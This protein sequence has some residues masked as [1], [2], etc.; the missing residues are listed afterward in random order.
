[1]I[2]VLMVMMLCGLSPCALGQAA[3]QAV[4]VEPTAA[5]GE[6]YSLTLQALALMTVLTLLPAFLLMMTSFTRIVIVLAIL[7]PIFE[8]NTLVG[9]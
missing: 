4:V 2:R 5:G 6:S 7:L 1:M 8:L 3:V 9:G